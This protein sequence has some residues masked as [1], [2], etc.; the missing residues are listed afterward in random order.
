MQIEDKAMYRV[1]LD[2]QKGGKVCL[3]SVY[4]YLLDY[5]SITHVSLQS[6]LI[7]IEIGSWKVKMQI[8]YDLEK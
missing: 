8:R 5:V 4:W 3:E 7:T 1:L 6:L 2:R